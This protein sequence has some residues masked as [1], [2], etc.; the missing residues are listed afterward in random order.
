MDR[1]AWMEIYDKSYQFCTAY[2]RGKTLQ[3]KAYSLNLGSFIEMPIKAFDS[4]LDDSECL[5]IDL[6]THTMSRSSGLL[7]EKRQDTWPCRVYTFFLK[8]GGKN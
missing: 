8:V 3:F 2:I 7:S 5:T 6:N 1:V 4:R